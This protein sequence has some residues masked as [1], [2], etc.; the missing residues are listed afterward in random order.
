MLYIPDFSYDNH[1]VY[2]IKKGDTLKK[3][4]E[5]LDV[6]IQYLRAFHNMR[7]PLEDLIEADFKS[8]LEFLI[9]ESK[10]ARIKRESHREG[11]NFANNYKLPFMPQGLDSDYLATYTIKNGEQEHSLKEE[12][13]VR[14][15]A[16]DKNGFSLIEIDRVSQV[17]VDGKETDSKADELSEK[18]ASVFYPLQVVIDPNGELA[19]IYNFEDIRD[20]W[21]KV[22]LAVLK[23]F[24][25][26][27]LEEILLKFENRLKDNEIIFEALSK[28]WFLKVFFNKLNIDYTEQLVTKREIAFPL[29]QQTGNVSFSIEQSILPNVDAYNL[30]NVTQN[31]TL[32]DARSKNDFENDLLFPEDNQENDT[33]EKATGS[34]TAYYFLDPK[35]HMPESIYLECEIKLEIPQ[36]VTV[37]ISNLKSE[38]KLDLR[39]KTSFLCDEKEKKSSNFF[40]V[41]LELI[42]GK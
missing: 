9:I 21:Y 31:G 2:K 5:E 24:Q 27:V 4:A 3:V 29:S 6:E 16:N 37:V 14:W 15:L 13:N 34:Y 11:V 19:A 33:P 17:Y 36:K 26:E 8:H 40:K 28:D 18:T 30:V 1:F 7:C 25:G 22:E 10:E 39:S 12:I 35:T 20:R 41:F 42:T 32:S 23:D 38:A